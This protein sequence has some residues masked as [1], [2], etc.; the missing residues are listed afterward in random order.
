MLG[1]H[2]MFRKGVVLRPACTQEG[3]KTLQST[4]GGTKVGVAQVLESCIGD[5]SA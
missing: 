4:F 1:L 3:G 5:F 2:F